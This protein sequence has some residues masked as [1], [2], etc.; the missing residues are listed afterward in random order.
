MPSET[1]KDAPEKEISRP[2]TH[3]HVLMGRQQ[4]VVVRHAHAWRPPTDVMED[5]DQMIVLVEIAGMR[6]GEFHI[7]LSPQ[8]LTISGTRP[9]PEQS[10]TA[11]HQLEVRYGEFRTDV[12]L[13]WPV[14]E[15]GIRAQYEDGFLRV[16][17]P[18]ARTQRVRVIPVDREQD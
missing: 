14:D 2:A 5:E 7:A 10:C 15:N 4:F 1:E 16:E 12:G 17:L 3:Y 13:P 9:M 18:R 8:R 11:Y 6:Y